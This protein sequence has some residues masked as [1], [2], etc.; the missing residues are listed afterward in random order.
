MFIHPVS[1]CAFENSTTA[2]PNTSVSAKISEE[3]SGN[4]AGLKR[5][6]PYVA[7]AVVLATCAVI[8]RNKIA[9]ILKQ[10]KIKE[11]PPFQPKEPPQEQKDAINTL[12]AVIYKFDCFNIKP[13]TADEF[14]NK[15][16]VPKSKKEPD[17]NG[18]IPNKLEEEPVPIE[19]GA[20]DAVPFESETTE[21]EAGYKTICVGF[22]NG[23]PVYKKVEMPVKGGPVEDTFKYSLKSAKIG[24]S[25]IISKITSIRE[26]KSADIERIINENTHNGLINMPMMQKIANDFMADINR[27]PDRFHQAADLLE[28]SHLRQHIKGNRPATS[29]MFN[30]VDYMMTDPVLYKCY[31]NMPLEESANRL[32]LIN[33]RFV[34]DDKYNE[35]LEVTKFFEKTFRRLV[36]KYQFKRY[37]R[38]HGI[39]D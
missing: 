24:D 5:A 32:N 19:K 33:E 1:F 18:V 15:V 31:Q 4:N 28:L 30:L 34:N 2:M 6:L 7:S 3:T 12:P 39:K 35:A 22:N 25:A 29:E 8:F 11:Q 10:P 38:A 27:G 17:I 21:A 16:V 9:K 26:D 23:L 37:N 14:P 13:K 36:E 20:N